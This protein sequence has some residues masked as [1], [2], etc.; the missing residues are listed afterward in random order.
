M[1]T[2][3]VSII[4]PVYNA[5]NYIEDCIKSLLSQT[6]GNIEIILV[7]DGSPDRCPDI[8]DEYMRSDKRVKVVHQEN[9]GLPGARNAGLKMAEGSFVMFVDPDDFITADAVYRLMSSVREDDDI[10]IFN[11]VRDD[12]K[13]PAETASGSGR[14]TEISDKDR[15]DILA[16][17]FAPMTERFPLL[18][19][20]RV[21]A[22]T[23]LYRKAFL[24]ENNIR[25]EEEV[26]VHED[27][28]FAVS[29][30]HHAKRIRHI[31]LDIYHYRYNPYSIT[32]GYRDNYPEEMGRMLKCL[33]DQVSGYGDPVLTDKLFADRVSASLIQLLIR[34]YCHK[35]N[36]RPYKTRKLEYQKIREEEPYKSML[37]KTAAFNKDY[38]AK[39]RIAVLLLKINSFCIM[40]MIFSR[41][42]Q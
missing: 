25:F 16:D 42:K 19:D 38:P 3:T 39:K 40:D 12:C 1:M 35:D 26:R 32:K 18:H 9:K 7:D 21:S 11:I 29:V 17:T 6:C 10:L 34:H 37:K 8:C 20:A 13:K 14:I 27:I 23:K 28:P 4:V 24:D 22:C 30:Y 5:E 33:S 36:G 2:E 15:Q 41:M 31:D